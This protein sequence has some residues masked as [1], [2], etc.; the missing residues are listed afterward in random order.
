M[1]GLETSRVE[2]WAESQQGSGTADVRNSRPNHGCSI[3]RWDLCRLIGSDDPM[4]L[5]VV[6]TIKALLH[7][8]HKDAQQL[9]NSVEL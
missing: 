3:S 1:E 6:F 7:K 2:E 9:Q 8:E 4:R 5:S